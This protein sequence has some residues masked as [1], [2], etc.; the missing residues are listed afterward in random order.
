MKKDGK[1][2]STGH[3]TT[4]DGKGW[5]RTMTTHAQQ[6]G[7]SRVIV[8]SILLV[9]LVGVALSVANPLLSL[10]MERWGIS[11]TVSGLTA[12]AAGLGT[13]LAVPLVPRLSRL[14]GVPA[15]ISVALAI[16]AAAMMLFYLVPNVLA[17]SL[18]R[19]VLGCGIG[20]IF[21]LAEYW[22][23]AAANPAK[24]GLVMGFYATALYAGFAAGPVILALIGTSGW[25]PYGITGALMA[26]GLIPLAL[27]GRDTPRIDEPA[28]GSVARFVFSVPTAT[29]GAL[30]FGAV[31]TGIV[32]LLPVHN[33]RLSFSEQDAAL[34]L[35]A[36]TLGNV[37]FQ[38]PI[39]LL[40]DRMDRRKLLFVLAATSTLLALALPF[41]PP[42]FW[43]FAG[44][45]LL[46]GGMSGAIYT[47]GLAHLGARFSGA[48]LASANAAFVM[49]YSF[50]LMVGPPALG[51][52]MDKAGALGLPVALGLLMG[53]YAV[54]VLTRLRLRPETRV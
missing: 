21:T 38:L 36:F 53:F 19:F 7:Q 30:I 12:T 47:V 35:S 16:S 50:G 18:L 17:W 8:A 54:L 39:G 4:E 34:L 10:E 24:R 13:V 22:I 11:S 48:D 1:H 2:E 27:A 15:V 31:E 3:P 28:S 45:L 23:N 14:F 6:N 40:S 42:G 49:L 32:V 20:I 29:F 5:I 43:R 37:L 52:G 41:G 33:V 51:Y 26:F 9:T 44:L 46:L 25:L